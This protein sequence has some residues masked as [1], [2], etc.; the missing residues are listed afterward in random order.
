MKSNVI[1]FILTSLDSGK[2]TLIVSL[3]SVIV[4]FVITAAFQHLPPHIVPSQLRLLPPSDTGDEK[5]VKKTRSPPFLSGAFAF[6]SQQ[7]HLSP[8]RIPVL[9]GPSAPWLLVKPFIFKAP[10]PLLMPASLFA[11]RSTQNKLGKYI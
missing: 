4:I 10:H 7:C 3:D 9:T 8:M 6:T 2:G 11:V 1:P 5:H